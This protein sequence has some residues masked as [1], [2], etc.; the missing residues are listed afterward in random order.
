MAGEFADR[1]GFVAAIGNGNQCY[2]HAVNVDVPSEW[3]AGIGTV[4]DAATDTLSRDRILGGSNGTSAV[5]FSAGTKQ[6]YITYG[7]AI[8]NA[9]RSAL[10]PADCTS[11]A[12]FLDDGT[13][14]TQ[15]DFTFV[16]RN[17]ETATWNVNGGYGV[18]L[19]P[20][21]AGHDIRILEIT[22][23]ASSFEYRM[24]VRFTGKTN[25]NAA[26]FGFGLTDNTTGEVYI[27][28]PRL[29]TGRFTGLTLGYWTDVNN[30]SSN[31]ATADTEVVGIEGGL[32]L[33]VVK[34]SATD[35]DFRYSLDGENFVDFATAHDASANL[36]ID[37]IGMAVNNINSWPAQL[38]VGAFRKI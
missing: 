24:Y 17:Q 31:P 1:Q 32:W 12:L 9:R 37:R 26:H 34:N 7:A 18:V 2:Y 13:S 5:N 3:E 6:I 28:G 38:A 33:S 8:A 30:F 27:F 16:W 14:L 21:S 19:A 10:D 22:D 23:T 11:E 15:G 29:G 25:V 20:S 4:T 35:W 36:T